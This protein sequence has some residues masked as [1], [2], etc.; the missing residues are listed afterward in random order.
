MQL[1]RRLFIAGASSL[2]LSTAF[3]PRLAS[4]AGER[5]VLRLQ[6]RQ[7]EVGG[8]PAPRYGVAIGSS[9]DGL[10]LNEGDD[11][12]VRLENHLPVPSG[13]HWHGFDPPWRQDGVPYISGPPIGPG[14]FA[15]YKFPAI[16]VDTRWMHSHFGL[17]E[18]NLLAA[19]LIVQKKARSK[20]ACRRS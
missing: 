19:P 16:P 18:Q 6:T 11:I 7:I 8:K 20:A 17:Q 12:D 2:A 14:E 5:K 15:D 1:S 4:A 10:I 3:R 9:F 13:L